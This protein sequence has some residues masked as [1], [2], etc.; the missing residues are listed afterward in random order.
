MEFHLV[1]R[2]FSESQEGLM[3]RQ[4]GSKGFQGHFL[5]P[6]HRP[7]KGGSVTFQKV[8][9]GISGYHEVSGAF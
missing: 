3:V 4:G 1:S 7:I 2:A 5:G 6:I 8:S 9:E